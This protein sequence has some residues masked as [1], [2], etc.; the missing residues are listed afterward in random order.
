MTPPPPP[1]IQPSEFACAKKIIV[2]ATMF[3][4]SFGKH[5]R[6]EYY[7]YRFLTSISN[8]LWCWRSLKHIFMSS[9]PI[10]RW[11]LYIYRHFTLFLLTVK[12]LILRQRHTVKGSPMWVNEK[13]DFIF[14]VG[15]HS[16]FYFILDLQ[17]CYI[18]SRLYLY[19]IYLLI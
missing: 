18:Q 11:Y 15:I 19:W 17:N 2:F 16:S 9:W 1:F 13:K 7:L 3:Y 10:V 5:R 8:Y 6:L 12:L 4:G 14:R